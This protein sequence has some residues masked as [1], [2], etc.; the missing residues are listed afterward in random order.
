MPCLN[1]WGN[2]GIIMIMIKRNKQFTCLFITLLPTCSNATSEIT[3][4]PNSGC[5]CTCYTISDGFLVINHWSLQRNCLIKLDKYFEVWRHQTI[6]WIN[7]DLS[8]VRINDNHFRAIL[9][10]IYQ[11]SVT[12]IGLKI[13][14]YPWDQ[15]VKGNDDGSIAAVTSMGHCAMRNVRWAKIVGDRLLND[16]L[17]IIWSLHVAVVLYEHWAFSQPT[18][19]TFYFSVNLTQK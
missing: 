6:T 9:Q 14:I 13:H 18:Y 8:S 3:S 19:I 17:M 2:F 11:P 15:W 7:D 1:V 5:C 12:K 10:K 4:S 16:V